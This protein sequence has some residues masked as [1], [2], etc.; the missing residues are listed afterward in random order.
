MFAACVEPECYKDKEWQKG[1]RL[2]AN[3][4]YIIETVEAGSVRFETCTCKE[5]IEKILENQKQLK[6]F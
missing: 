2:Y 1:I 5:D 4:G 3:R 6:L